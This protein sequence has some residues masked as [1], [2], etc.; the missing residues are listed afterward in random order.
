MQNEMTII[1]CS[2]F[3]RVLWQLLCEKKLSLRAVLNALETL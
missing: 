1:D 3:Q 2:N